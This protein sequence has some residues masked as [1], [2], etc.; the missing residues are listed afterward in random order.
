MMSL[1]NQSHWS[2]GA[3]ILPFI[4]QSALHNNL[5][6]GQRTLWQNLTT[7]AGLALLQTPLP[8]YVCPSCPG[9]AL[10]NF[11]QNLADN[12]ADPSAAWYN[13]HV[14]SNGTDRIAIAKSNYVMVAC[15]SVST[16]PPVWPQFGPPTG[17][18]WL[19]SRCRMADITDGT[20]N[21]AMV[22][23]RAFRFHNLNVGAGNALGFSS[24]TCTPGTSAGIKAAGMSVLGLP[25][26]GINFSATNRV[27]QPRGFHSNHVGGAQFVFADGS[28]H[29]ISQNIDYNFSTI[30]AR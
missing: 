10:N 28:V 13:R 5:A 6:V 12:P 11:D 20:S 24:V 3:L 14:T 15:T 8:T 19:N 29:F 18:A 16:T 25:Y 7:P 1:T 22:G 4:E 21:V 27:H 2:W 17:T 9:P 30:P 23:E 26:N